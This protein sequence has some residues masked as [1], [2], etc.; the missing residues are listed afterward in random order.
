MLQESTQ[1]ITAPLVVTDSPQTFIVIINPGYV[2]EI[3]RLK[4]Q[5][6]FKPIVFRL[7]GIR[8]I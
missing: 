4:S 5:T 7:C 6:G 3:K 8:Y 2:Q 1:K